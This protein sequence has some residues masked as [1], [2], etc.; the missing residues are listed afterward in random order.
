MNIIQNILGALIRTVYNGIAGMMAEPEQISLLAISII[1]TTI[2]FK[3]LML[4]LTFNQIKS[5]RM[6]QKLQPKQQEI[7]KKYK[8]NPEVMNQKIQELFREHKYNP[9]SGCL[10]ILIQFPIIISF[11]YVMRNPGLYIFQDA[12]PITEIAKNFFW[13]ANIENPDALLWGLPLI[14]G[15][16]QYAYARLTMGQ[17]QKPQN[18][19]AQGNQ[20]NQMQ[21]MNTMMM[22]VMPIMMFFFARTL[23]AGLIIYWIVGNIFEIGTRL[24]IN[25]IHAKEDEGS[26]A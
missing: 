13:I 20:Q 16:V 5:Q 9:L 22:Y 23:P 17:Q 14:N 3:L 18:A 24:I 1:I 25:R 12:Q 26:V 4:P 19:A 10:P 2:I 7:Q 11:F 15:L 21:T 6:M 8:N